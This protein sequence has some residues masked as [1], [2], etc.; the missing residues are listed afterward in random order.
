MRMSDIL[1][2]PTVLVLN[3]AWQA[4]NTR[5]VQE[6]I[7]QLAADA[8]TALD[9]DGDSMVPV[10][11]ED[12]IKLPV[13]PQD[14]VIHTPKLSIRVPTVVVLCNYTKVPKKR[15]KFSPQGIFHR[16]QG[17]C[18]YTGRRLTKGEANIDHVVPRARGGSSSWKNCVLVDKKVNFKKADRTPEEAG[19][20]LIRQ[21][22]EPREVPVS[23]LIR[24]TH[25]VP[26]WDLFLRD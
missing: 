19:L 9:I 16:D 3:R 7:L 22:S 23:M 2:Q 5:S 21:P 13:R 26:E 15:P 8:A 18:Q 4:I 17:T 10:K 11:W 12:W 24:N 20:K 1:H 14:Q 6:A 25:K